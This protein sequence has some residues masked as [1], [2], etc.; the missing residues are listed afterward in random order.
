MSPPPPVT[1]TRVI[2]AA[3]GR[4]PS[5]ADLGVVAQHEAVRDGP[6]RQPV[7]ANVA[8]DQAVLDAGREPRDY[9]ALQDDAMFDLGLADLDALPHGGKWSDI[10]ARDPGARADDH[11]TAHDRP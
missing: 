2:G 5:D 10:G 6:H 9:C 11:R 8:S 7:D 4:S 3:R 1:S